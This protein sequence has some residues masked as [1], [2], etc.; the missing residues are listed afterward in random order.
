MHTSLHSGMARLDVVKRK[1]TSAGSAPMAAHQSVPRQIEM[2]SLR[3]IESLLAS[4]EDRWAGYW[5]EMQSLLD[6]LRPGEGLPVQTGLQAKGKRIRS[7]IYGDIDLLDPDLMV[8]VDM[9]YVQRLRQ[10]SQMGLVHLVYPEARHSRFDH[11]LGVFWN[12][13]RACASLVENILPEQKK[14][15]LV[16]AILHDIG[17]GPFSHCTEMWE[18]SLSDNRGGVWGWSENKV[19]G[20]SA[21]HQFPEDKMTVKAKPHEVNGVRLIY[22]HPIALALVR[23]GLQRTGTDDQ[24]AIFRREPSLGIRAM[25]DL[26]HV[27]P[28]T[29]AQMIVGDRGNGGALVDIINGDL[30]A[31]K[32]DYYRRDAYF[33]GAGQAGADV[34][35][36][37]HNMQL[38]TLP[39]QMGG[40]K[41]IAW[42]LKAV[43]DLV[44]NLMSKKYSFLNTANHPVSQ[45][46]NA[47]LATAFFEGYRALQ[48][49]CLN[50]G[51]TN[52]CRDAA[53]KLLAYLPFM[54]DQDVWA[55]LDSMAGVRS[56]DPY[57][58]S[59]C[60]VVK[61][62]VRGLRARSLFARSVPLTG[63]TCNRLTRRIYHA[64]EKDYSRRIKDPG[65]LV[66][67]LYL[68]DDPAYV[69][70]CEERQQGSL[71][72]ITLVD[73]GWNADNQMTLPELVKRKKVLFGCE[74]ETTRPSICIL[75]RGNARVPVGLSNALDDRDNLVATGIARYEYAMSFVQVLNDNMGVTAH[76]HG[77]RISDESVKALPEQVRRAYA[78]WLLSKDA[79]KDGKPSTSQN[80]AR[81]AAAHRMGPHPANAN[82]V[83]DAIAHVLPRS[84]AT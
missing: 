51:G 3:Q 57:R 1:K 75:P 43:N 19:E 18:E 65:Q 30:D 82:L 78:E 45:N 10:I 53:G 42:P 39:R 36:I 22:D 29:V 64:V 80:N 61:H 11:T 70:S 81:E 41:A 17:H 63:D 74:E 54:E 84:E 33:T 23:R 14:A 49:A 37:V 55:F 68:I 4:V 7:A 46:A 20:V 77:E 56:S 73:W 12:A 25:L 2:R 24:R 34:E 60:R 52:S 59:C 83:T 62:I 9:P 50:L 40:H 6:M 13:D 79:N 44:F 76:R 15:V 26:L 58:Q 5:Q 38:V 72:G 66:D 8:L 31:D 28:L 47:M 69:D 16:A 71:E 48:D 35:Y 67:F 21:Y 27:D 32:F